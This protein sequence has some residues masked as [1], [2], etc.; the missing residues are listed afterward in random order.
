MPPASPPPAEAKKKESSAAKEERFIDPNAKASLAIFRPTNSF[1]RIPIK[2][3]GNPN[4]ISQMQ[5]M[6]A[7]VQNLDPAFIKAYVEFFTAEL[8]KRDNIN[9]LIAPNPK[10]SPNAPEARGLEKAVDALT[11]PIIDGKANNNEP[12]LRAYT[13]ALFSSELPKLLED[14]YFTR[15]DAMIVLGMAGSRNNTALDLY[16]AQLKMPDQLIWVKMWAAHGYTY[17]TASGKENIDA[18]RAISGAEA[19]VEFLN[20]NPK[21][22]YFARFRALEALG[23]IRVATASRPDLKL[24][25]ASVIAAI[26]VDPASHLET[27]AWAAWSLGMLRVAPQVSPYNFSL[28]GHEIGQLAVLIGSKIV[29]EYDNHAEN[30]DRDKSQA[31]ADTA[32]LMF[33]LVPSF[34]GED[35]ATDSGLLRSSH[36][37]LAAA[38]PVLVKIDEKIKAVTRKA[39]ELYQAG[40]ANQ[41]AKRDELQASINDLRTYLDQNKPKDRKLLPDGPELAL[42]AA[43]GP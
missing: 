22:P 30:F 17:A 40:G 25:A 14:N 27:R 18:L 3:V 20:S 38:K 23:S 32:L 31:T 29:E 21:L 10:M 16:A 43:G 19:L 6:A 39:Y 7:R 37:S 8:T 41:K 15:I 34:S 33:Q 36:P 5:N 9:A 26:L 42:P 28:V 11:K 35:G 1:N 24:D 4:A 12:F 13:Q 2:T